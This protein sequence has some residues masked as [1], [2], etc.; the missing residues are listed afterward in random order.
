MSNFIIG[1]II[2]SLL[3][4]IVKKRGHYVIITILNMFSLTLKKKQ[5][6]T[7]GKDCIR[8]SCKVHG[9]SKLVIR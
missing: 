5:K 8:N 2:A 1:F 9:T 6:C 7:C 4:L 3:S